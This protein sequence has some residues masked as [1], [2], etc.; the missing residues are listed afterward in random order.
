MGCTIIFVSLG[1]GLELW[2]LTPR[3]TIFQLYR[4]GLF[5]WWRKL[6]YPEK[7]T[8]LPQVTDKLY[9]IKLNQVHLAMSGIQT[10]LVVIGTDCTGSCKSNYHT[11][12]TMTAL[13]SL[14]GS[15][16]FK[17][18]CWYG[19]L[20]LYSLMWFFCTQWNLTNNCTN[21]ITEFSCYPILHYSGDKNQ[22]TG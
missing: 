11:I 10:T 3:S 14:K 5:Y 15:E 7:T 6:K 12:T 22:I 2:R 21:K 4:G 16:F 20:Y 8:D 9:H 19:G 18:V 17:E 1:L 13:I